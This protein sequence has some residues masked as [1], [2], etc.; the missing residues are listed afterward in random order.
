MMEALFGATRLLIATLASGCD[1]PASAK[2]ARAR[3]LTRGASSEGLPGSL[4]LFFRWPSF[5][6]LR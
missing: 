4:G 3:N 5:A 2:L 1:Q 6:K